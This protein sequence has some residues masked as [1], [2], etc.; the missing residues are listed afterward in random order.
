MKKFFLL[1]GVA[2]M[3]TVAVNAQTSK[4]EVKHDLTALRKEERVTKKEIRKEKKELRKL[5]GK[6]VS[7]Q[8]RVAFEKDFG[9]H[10]GA[11]WKRGT[12]YD[13]VTFTSK[14][15][16]NI[17][18]YYDYDAQ[19]VG[20]T[21]DKNFSDIPMKAQNYI[22]RK[23]SGYTKVGVIYFDDN[24]SND[25]DMVLYKTAFDDADNYFVVLKKGNEEIILRSDLA[26]TVSFFKKM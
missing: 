10:P 12:F 7:F 11:A 2:V 17:T 9:D 19:L 24:E 26:G 23:Y 8:S 3:M 15:G 1:S 22:N 21:T 5:E 4:K 20:T 18:A 16:K 13:E 14:H 25:L 6:D